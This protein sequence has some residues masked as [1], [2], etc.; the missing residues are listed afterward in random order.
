MR[1]RRPDDWHVHL[2]DGSMLA[3]TVPD[4][5]RTFRRAV[6][7]PNLVPPVQDRDGIQAYRSRIEAHIP[8]GSNFEPLMTA[9]LTSATT[10]E[11]LREAKDEL[12]AVKLYP[13]N[14]TTNSASG[15]QRIEDGWPVF[16]AMQSLGIPLLVHGEVTDAEVDFFDREKVFIERHLAPIVRD[17]PGLKV[18]LE[19]ITTADAVDFVR[20]ARDGVGATITPH[21][22]ELT[23]NDL[24]AGGLRPH[25]YCLP[26][27]K[28][29]RH[30]DAVAAAACS[31]EAKFF[32]GTDSAPHTRAKKEQDCGCAGIFSAP[33]A[34]AVY[35]EVFSA[36][37]AI[38]KLEAFASL[39]GPRFYGVPVNEDFIELDETAW[40]PETWRETADGPVRQY[41]GGAEIGWSVTVP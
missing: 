30:R 35:A 17:F 22:M 38:E 3:A 20:E 15:L 23:R 39:N 1:I 33:T 2:R 7:M 14:A 40:T 37:G 10:P 18:V 41:R 26:V 36:R 31:G 25:H 5:A 29:A 24:F 12:F 4:T 9:Y 19:H 11:V 8:A 32:L 6:V 13:A 16:E 27:A 21:H 34:M 28:R